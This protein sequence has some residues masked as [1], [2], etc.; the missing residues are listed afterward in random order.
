MLT[1]SKI[2]I[3][4]AAAL[5]LV[6][7]GGGSGTA[8]NAVIKGVVAVGAPLPQMTIEVTDANGI[9]VQSVTADDGS[10][11]VFDPAGTTLAAPFRISVRALLGTTEISLE[12]FALSR[13]SLANV[14]PL[15]TALSA[16]LSAPQGYDPASLAISDLTPNQVAQATTQLASALQP[17]LSF[18]GV[19]QGAFDPLSRQ[20]AADGTGIDSVLDRLNVDYSSSGVYFSNKF[21]LLTDGLQ[22]T[23]LS[24]T[25]AGSSGDLPRGIAPP[26]VSVIGELMQKLKTC[27]A[28]PAEQRVTYTTNAA[29]RKI[30]SGTLHSNCRSLVDGD[31]GY[32]AQ[33]MNFGQRWLSYLS[34]T[35]FDQSTKFLIVPQYVVDRRN[36]TPAWTGDDQVA[37][38]Y[39]IHLIDKNNLTY[40]MPEVLALVGNK[41]LMRGNQRKFDV[42][43]QPVFTKNNDNNG[44]NNFVEG[45]LRIGLDP[46]LI[47]VAGVG[48]YQYTADQASPLPK[49]LCAWVTGPLLQN[50]VAHD[51]D[52]PR[53]GVLMVPPHSDLVTR[54]DYSAI[55]IKYPFDFDPINVA[56]HRSRLLNDC[57]TRHTVDSKVEVASAETGNQ[58]TIDGAKTASD[59]TTTFRAYPLLGASSAYPTSLNRAGFCPTN[60]DNRGLTATTVPGWCSATRRENLTTDADRILFSQTYPDPKNTIFTFYI[61]VDPAYSEATPQNA[62]ASYTDPALFLQSAEKV[63]VRILG[64]MPFVDKDTNSIY[65]G[66]Q[67]FRTIG[68]SMIDTYLA[69]RAP[70]LS[71]NTK[72][73]AAWAIPSGTEG[74]DRLGLSGWFRKA[75]LS[76]IGSATYTDNFG[77]PR[78]KLSEQFTLSEDWYGYDYLSYDGG[79]YAATAT[80]A[81]REIWVRSYDRY[82]RQIQTVEYAVR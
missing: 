29:G 35:D 19:S 78:S 61:F 68:K 51:K 13:D 30:Y 39:N 54:R 46:T 65:A 25:N 27:F 20:F 71:K 32:L 17:V 56:E 53:G 81:Y 5:A 34:S 50:G 9:K 52:N 70:T 14:T 18:A 49:I 28:V 48:T 23:Q 60:T 73:N 80:S 3:V 59:S 58:F 72:I 38:V 4:A 36:S 47:P 10:Y 66:N 75:D 33:G 8:S 22:N 15:T 55:R 63:Q 67:I 82:N 16:L 12:S 69:D 6:S 42:S 45:R 64:A 62:Y 57:K 24:V 1:H 11:E 26:G 2:M 40:T 79:R 7:C 31:Y 44:K 41:L 76:R 43:V 37:Y 21:E 77:L 74:I